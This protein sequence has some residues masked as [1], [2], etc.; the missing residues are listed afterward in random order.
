MRERGPL[1]SES[2]SSK[3][4]MAWSD[5]ELSQGHCLQGVGTVWGP[6]PIIPQVLL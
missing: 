4:S 1:G 3:A 2:P 5:C 6:N